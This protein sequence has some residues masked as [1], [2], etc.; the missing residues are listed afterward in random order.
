MLNDIFTKQ[1]P[2]NVGEGILPFRTWTGPACRFLDVAAVAPSGLS[3]LLYWM[4]K[5]QHGYVSMLYII[6]PGGV[7]APKVVADGHE[8]GHCFDICFF[9]F[10]VQA[11]CVR[12]PWWRT[13]A[14][15][16]IVFTYF[17]LLF[18]KHVTTLNRESRQQLDGFFPFFL[19]R[20][21]SH[22]WKFV[23]LHILA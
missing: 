11:A 20:G 2:K 13:E 18:L 22:D 14:K 17:F 4:E 10:F 21:N 3:V 1:N 12:H 16:A 19:L 23:S 5:H 7:R 8:A 15:L 9:S 6:G